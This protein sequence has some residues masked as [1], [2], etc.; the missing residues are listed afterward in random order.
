V[1]QTV[2][3]AEVVTRRL[4]SLAALVW[5]LALWGL[6]TLRPAAVRARVSPWRVVGPGSVE[7]WDAL[8]RWAASAKRGTLLACLRAAPAEWTLR[9]AA[10]RAATTVA[11]C[12]LPTL[13]PPSIAARAFL[14]AERAR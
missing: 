10:A 12:A 4:Y 11:A 3:P 7:R 5:A 13:A 1:T 2:T 14:G 8:R 9:A 6:E